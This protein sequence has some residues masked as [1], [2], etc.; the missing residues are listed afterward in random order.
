M[1]GPELLQD[2]ITD[3]PAAER[4]E[5]IVTGLHERFECGA[6]VLLRLQR[7]HLH[8]VA[9]RGLV[10]EAHGRKFGLAQHPRLSAIMTSVQGPALSGRQPAARPLRRPAGQSARRT[11]AGA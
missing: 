5:R 4:F 10:A 8:P 3:M 1:S 11:L 9:I 6:V 7:E 2:L